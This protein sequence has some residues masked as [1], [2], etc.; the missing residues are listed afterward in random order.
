M[1]E[2]D[3]KILKSKSR[4]LKGVIIS[5]RKIIILFIS[6]ILCVFSFLSLLNIEMVPLSTLPDE[7][8][9][10]HTLE[11]GNKREYYLIP[12]FLKK[13]TSIPVSIEEIKV[14]NSIDAVYTGHKKPLIFIY[15]S[16]NKNV[17]GASGFVSL[18]EFLKNYPT[19]ILFEGEPILIREAYIFLLVPADSIY[20][21]SRCDLSLNY[22]WLGVLKGKLSCKIQ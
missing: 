5:N 11:D 14:E 4:S 13:E 9:E 3:E 1:H 17:K 2:G 20:I 8:Q 18:S 15:E 19:A 21:N 16:Y 22:V 6:I 7:R 12:I 10:Q